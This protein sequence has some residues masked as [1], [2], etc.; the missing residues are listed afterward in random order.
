MPVEP[1]VAAVPLPFVPAAPPGAEIVP[2]FVVEVL[3]ISIQP[4]PPPPP[5]TLEVEP[6]PPTPPGAVIEPALAKVPKQ[7]T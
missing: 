2:V 5:G 3:E 6:E 1:A 4:P 7:R